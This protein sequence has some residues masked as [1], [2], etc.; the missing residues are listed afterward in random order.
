MSWSLRGQGRGPVLPPAGPTATPR[1]VRLW[2]RGLAGG[3][4]QGCGL[5]STGY[6]PSRAAAS[7]PGGSLRGPGS[8]GAAGAAVGGKGEWGGGLGARG[9]PASRSSS[10]AMVGEA[11]VSRETAWSCLASVMSTPLICKSAAH[12]T[13]PG[14]GVHGCRAGLP[15]YSRKGLG[16]RPAGCLPG[17]RRPPQR[18]GR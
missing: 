12:Q 16:R 6:G 5:T 3:Q 1:A 15:P 2:R 13:A 7:R 18:C 9:P 14:K 11:A 8:P 4:G 17:G 10:R